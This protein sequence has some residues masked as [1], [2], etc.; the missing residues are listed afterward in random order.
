MIWESKRP[1]I[2]AQRML[3][4]LV[5]GMTCVSVARS[6]EEGAPIRHDDDLPAVIANVRSSVVQIRVKTEGHDAQGNGF[7]IDSSGLIVTNYH[8]IEGAK[9][10]TAVLLGDRDRSALSV[11]GWAAIE[12]GNDLAL[13]RIKVGDKRLRPLPLTSNPPTKG[14]RVLAIGSGAYPGIVSAMRSGKDV[15]DMLQEMYHKNLYEDQM[16]F[17]LNTKWLQST[18]PIGSGSAGSPLVNVR[19]EV[20][21]IATWVCH[22][23]DRRTLNFFVSASH[24]RQLVTKAGTKALPLTKLPPARA[25]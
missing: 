9:A 18:V 14:E 22:T 1:E 17:D 5:L 20:L 4:S 10:I 21:G 12:P 7:L 19:G 23:N 16:G 11:E 15:R 24:I 25:R 3:L 8:V 13:L 2:K 6:G